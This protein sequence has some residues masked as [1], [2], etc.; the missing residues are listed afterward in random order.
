MGAVVSMSSERKLGVH[1]INVCVLMK[2]GHNINYLKGDS[3]KGEKGC[4]E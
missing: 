3:F 4:W 1:V 2:H